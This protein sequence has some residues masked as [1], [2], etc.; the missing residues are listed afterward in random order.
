MPLELL[1]RRELGLVRHTRLRSLSHDDRLNSLRILHKHPIENISSPISCM[2]IDKV[3]NAFLL[4]GGISGKIYLS[5]LYSC[6]FYGPARREELLLPENFRHKHFV[7]GCQWFHD[8]RLFLSVSTGGDLTAWD[9]NRLSALETY[10]VSESGKWRPQLHWNDVEK[11]NPLVAITDGS[12][13]IPLFDL[14]VGDLAQTV[15]SRDSS[16]VR[17]VRWLPS[18]YHVLFSG[19]N[20]GQLSVYDIRSNRGA[21]STKTIKKDSCIRAI[22]LSS[23]GHHLVLVLYTG[24]V[25]LY[26]AVTMRRLGM[27]EFR[28]RRKWSEKMS[29]SLDQFAVADEGSFIRVALPVGEDI[30]WIR[31]SKDL[32]QECRGFLCSTLSGHLSRVNACVYRNESQQLY[33][34]GADRNV[35]C[36]A[37]EC[38]RNRVHLEAETAKRIATTNDWS[39]DDD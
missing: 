20:D 13:Q 18:K 6:D 7:T 28:D 8:I 15:R 5:N 11:S 10:R 17:A 32:S 37:P 30:E 4:C 22:R 25:M 2:D 36:W 9:L 26:D 14:R 19:N 35:L 33:S 24:T 39:D 21:L 31:F 23:D 16:V 12:N 29:N 34:A 27:Y 3:E 38:E 1:H